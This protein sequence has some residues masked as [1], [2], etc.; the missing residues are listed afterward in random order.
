MC[1]HELDDTGVDKSPCLIHGQINELDYNTSDMCPNS[2]AF[3]T[4]EQQRE[5]FNVYLSSDCDILPKEVPLNL[6]LPYISNN[7][8]CQEFDSTGRFAKKLR[9]DPLSAART[10]D[11]CEKSSSNITAKILKQILSLQLKSGSSRHHTVLVNNEREL[12]LLENELKRN[13]FQMKCRASES[14]KI[15]EIKLSGMHLRFLNRSDFFQEPLVELYDQ[16][17]LNLDLTFFPGQINHPFY[18]DYIGEMPGIPAFDNLFDT[19]V[20]ASKKADFFIRCAQQKKEWN[21]REELKKYLVCQVTLLG[22]IAIEFLK[23][24]IEFQILG[25]DIFKPDSQPNRMPICTLFTQAISLSGFAYDSIKNFVM[26]KETDLY[27]VNNEK[28]KKK[29]V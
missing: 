3:L 27:T 13:R 8:V 7:P 18:Y 6:H 19:S 15:R 9:I 21:F 1:K 26:D 17:N 2:A 20:E 28:A 22:T 23:L 24:S 5:Y 29:A 14:N 16:L 12:S 10:N 11:M 4:E 25:H